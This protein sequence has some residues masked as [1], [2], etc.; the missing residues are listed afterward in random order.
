[1][2]NILTFFN[3]AEPRSL[4]YLSNS[5]FTKI[6][7]RDFD[8]DVYRPG[9]R[10][11][12]VLRVVLI[13]YI[14]FCEFLSFVYIQVKVLYT[15]CEIVFN[16]LTTSQLLG[17]V[18]AYLKKIVSYLKCNVLYVI[19]CLF[20]VNCANLLNFNNFSFLNC[21]NQTLQATHMY[22]ARTYFFMNIYELM[23]VWPHSYIINLLVI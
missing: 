17:Y 6:V 14:L 2:T 5:N 10:A 16:T 15:V 18:Y 4:N 8:L 12:L 19:K 9:T 13:I 1:M 22:A 7:Y 11:L 3:F 21:H 20:P 23:Y